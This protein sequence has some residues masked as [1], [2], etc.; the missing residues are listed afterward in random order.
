M[1]KR[2]RRILT[3]LGGLVLLLTILSLFIILLGTGKLYEIHK[4]IISSTGLD[5]TAD[6]SFIVYFVVPSLILYLCVRDYFIAR[7]KHERIKFRR[8]YVRSVVMS[9]LVAGLISLYN[10]M[11]CSRCELAGLTIVEFFLM[12]LSGLV[13]SL[14]TVLIIYFRSK[15]LDL[16]SM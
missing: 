9:T 10:F 1:E 12:A 14:V 2:E 15:K 5:L 3:V 11:V 16:R 4:F 13:F 8:S 6:F 7:S